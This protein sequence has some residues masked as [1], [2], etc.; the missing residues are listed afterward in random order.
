MLGLIVTL[1]AF[2]CPNLMSSESPPGDPLNEETVI[3][4]DIRAE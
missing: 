1:M 3:E 4:T 2:E